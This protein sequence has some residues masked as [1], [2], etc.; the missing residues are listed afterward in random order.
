MY[1]PLLTLPEFKIRASDAIREYFDSSDLNEVVRCVDEMGCRPY[2]PEVVKRAISLGLD[3][4]PRERKLV[5]RLLA[6]LHPNLLAD[7]EMEAGSGMVLDAIE[8]LTIDIPDAKVSPFAFFSVL[9]SIVLVSRS[10]CRS[11]ARC[12]ASG[13][14]E[15][16]HR[17]ELVVAPLVVGPLPSLC[18]RGPAVR[19]IPRVYGRCPARVPAR[20]IS[21]R[22]H[23]RLTH[24]R[25]PSFSPTTGNQTNIP[26][27][28]NQQAVLDDD[29]AV[30]GCL[31]NIVSF[32]LD[33]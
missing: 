33:S 20:T 18:C 27:T 15:M 3:E 17:G 29:Q 23:W 22:A 25:P 26:V 5:S 7:G 8:E 10:A 19:D 9:A 31:I 1:G 24:P 14:E 2:H 12:S 32:S 30:L 16:M 11:A 28:M 6:C 13:G 4:G 21:H